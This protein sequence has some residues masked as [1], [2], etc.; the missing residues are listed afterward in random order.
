[1]CE[2]VCATIY[3]TLF[4]E[5]NLIMTTAIF[6][7]VQFD[8]ELLY[9]RVSARILLNVPQRELSY[10]AFGE[11]QELKNSIGLVKIHYYIIRQ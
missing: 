7:K 3:R 5:R 10:Q 1:M 6:S 4:P 11:K 8:M 2:P 9:C